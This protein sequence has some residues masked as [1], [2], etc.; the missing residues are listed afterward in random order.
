MKSMVVCLIALFALSGSMLAQGKLGDLYAKAAS[1]ANSEAFSKGDLSKAK[2]D[3]EST[4][5]ES[6]NTFKDSRNLSGIYYSNVPIRVFT[7]TDKKKVAQK[8]LV[9]YVEKDNFHNRITVYTQHSFETSE[10]K[11]VNPADFTSGT[12]PASVGVKTAIAAGGVRLDDGGGRFEYISNKTKTDAQGNQVADGTYFASWGENIIE[13][14]PGILLVHNDRTKGKPGSEENKKSLVTAKAF[15]DVV[16][17]YKAEKAEQAKLYTREYCW[18]KID[19]YMSKYYG[20]MDAVGYDFKLP[21]PGSTGDIPVFSAHR[22]AATKLIQ[23]LVDER[24]YK[25][26]KVLYAYSMDH[27]TSFSVIEEIINGSTVKTGRYVRFHVVCE[28]S[29]SSSK[30][31]NVWDAPNKYC[32]FQIS[33][34]E[35]MKGNAVNISEF[36][37]VYFRYGFNGPLWLSNEEDAM[38]YK[39]K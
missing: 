31:S 7:K 32:C 20:A 2:A 23:E 24:G 18:D 5:L 12:S 4:F 19:N 17:L 21:V 15:Y 11:L 26:I 9:E 8:F 3:M 36:S 34:G 14:E 30:S 16:V 22:A 35:K 6:K 10:S 28:S 25:H 29:K 1:K 37:G 13:I 39:G 38:K 27:G 33:V